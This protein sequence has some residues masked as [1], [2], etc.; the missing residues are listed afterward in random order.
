LALV[1]PP[2][3]ARV[4]AFEAWKGTTDPLLLGTPYAEAVL[5][6]GTLTVSGAKGEVGT[7]TELIVALPEGAPT[8]TAVVVNGQQIS[9]F[10]SQP[11][12]GLSAL[13]IKGSWGGL[14]FARGQEIL[15][16]SASSER[17]IGQFSVPP[18]AI[19]QLKARNAS[20]PLVYDTD[21]QSTDDANVP[22]LAPG[23]LLI[24]IKYPTP[25][26]DKLNI[27]G[28]IDGRSLLVRKGYNT[29]VR[30]AGRFIGHWADVTAHIEPG[31]QQTLTLQL[32]G[33]TPLGVFFDNVETILTDAFVPE[34]AGPASLA[35]ASGAQREAALRRSSQS[36][37]SQ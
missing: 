32:P 37:L 15:P 5:I 10:A 14:R 23:R 20:Y 17:W 24:F 2:T 6:A 30:N 27:T 21:P 4:V 18:A 7:S 26:D 3:S 25:I 33:Q 1:L 8:V 9:S 35:I 34:L 16:S 12:H 36:A 22:W 19:E 13:V 28:D 11:L 29:I 31:K